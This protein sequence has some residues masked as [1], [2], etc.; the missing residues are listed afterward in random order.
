M[1][2]LWFIPLFILLW[3]VFDVVRA[4]SRKKFPKKPN[5]QV[6]E[7]EVLARLGRGEEIPEKEIL[8]KL[9]PT[10]D[11]IKNR[12]DCSD[13]R[14]ISLLRIYL[15]FGDKL[16]QQAREKI[17]ETVISF[18]YW[19]DQPGKD[20]MCFWSENH[21]I[22]FAASEY[23]AGQTFPDE[24][25][26]ND[27]KSGKEHMATAAKRIEYWTDFRFNYGFTEWYSNVYY[28]EDLAPLS[29]LAE[30]AKDETIKL[31]AA[32][33]LDIFWFDVATHS[34]KGAFVSTGGRM[35]ST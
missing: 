35:Y 24:T 7:T 18:R 30:F 19:M 33:M 12:Y 11:F 10:F 21:Q 31:K 32:M 28:V 26:T 22:L 8:E 9:Q 17:K 2:Y 14:M 13:F 20:S 6:F 29:N 4:L 5:Y 23:L 15:Q 1:K 25:F 34:H 3:I 16:P 27:G